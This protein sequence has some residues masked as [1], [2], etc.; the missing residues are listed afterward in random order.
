MEASTKFFL[1]GSLLCLLL[2]RI[3]F[4]LALHFGIS[5]DFETFNIYYLDNLYPETIIVNFTTT[6]YIFNIFLIT[7]VIFDVSKCCSSKLILYLI[8]IIGFIFFLT[9]LYLN[10]N[11]LY[12]Q[13]I[14]STTEFKIVLFIQTIYYL[15]HCAYQMLA[16]FCR[17]DRKT[18]LTEAIVT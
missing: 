5:K 1:S 9:S 2:E 10:V 15:I 16:C 11:Y 3:I 4:F 14:T 12:I 7:G 18:L 6:S 13:N 17:K 8:A